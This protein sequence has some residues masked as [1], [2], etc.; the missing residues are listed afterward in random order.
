MCKSASSQ[1]YTATRISERKR[2]Q[3]HSTR[4]GDTFLLSGTNKA[5]ANLCV[6]RVGSWAAARQAGLRAFRGT[7]QVGDNVG[8]AACSR[9]SALVGSCRE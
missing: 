1:A 4:P 8:R 2:D 6:R 5:P 3:R 7:C 9:A